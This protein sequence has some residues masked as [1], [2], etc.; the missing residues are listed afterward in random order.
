MINFILI[1]SLH[2]N[3]FYQ[4][5]FFSIS[6][7][8]HFDS[9][10]TLWQSLSTIQSTFCDSD[11][12]AYVIDNK[13]LLRPSLNSKIGLHVLDLID[14]GSFEL[15]LTLYNTLLKRCTQLGK[16]KEGKLVHFHMFNSKFKDDLVIQNF[17]L[18]MYARCGNLKDTQHVFNEKLQKDMVTWTSMI[19]GYAQNERAKDT[20]VL[21]PRIL[22]EGTKLNYDFW[23]PFSAMSMISNHHSSLGRRYSATVLC[24]DNDFQALFYNEV[25]WNALIGG[26]AKKGEGEEALALYLRMQMEAYKP[27]QFTY[28][29][30]LSSY[31]SMGCLEQGKWLLAH[32]MKPGQKLVVYVGNTLLHM[33]AKLGKI[34]DVEKFFDKL[35]KVDVVSCNSMLTRYAQHGLGKEAMQQFEE[36]ISF[37]IEPNDIT[38]LFVLSSCSHARLLDEGKHYFGLMRKYSIE[39]KVSHYATIIDLLG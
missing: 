28:S 39:P 22:S 12:S 24:R 3:S 11:I 8:R 21:F 30:I 9:F 23:P 25:S 6:V 33:Y 29:G 14:C 31:L 18:F 32:L 26:Y 13:N 36:M 16:L 19:S 1:Y 4:L 37:G 20:L 7:K 34:R 17:V 2:V 27:I 10:R 15:D 38:V 35:V 5:F